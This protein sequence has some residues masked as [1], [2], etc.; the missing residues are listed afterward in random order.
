MAHRLGL[1]NVPVILYG[2]KMQNFI[3]CFTY[4]LW[5]LRWSYTMRNNILDFYYQLS[6]T[7]DNDRILGF[8]CECMLLYFFESVYA[9]ILLY[10][11]Q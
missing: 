2:V 7:L 5:P 9:A 1:G 11:N 3:C 8:K 6:C 4:A 10:W